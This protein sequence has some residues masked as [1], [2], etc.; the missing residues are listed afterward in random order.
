MRVVK[1]K[2]SREMRGTIGPIYPPLLGVYNAYRA[3][4]VPLHCTT[5]NNQIISRCKNAMDMWVFSMKMH[6]KC[7]GAISM[8]SSSI[9]PIAL[10]QLN[11]NINISR[12]KN[13]MDM[14]VFM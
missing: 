1:I 2:N 3:P 4:L 7:H 14:W 6:T 8:L 12:C 10:H 11:I 5:T 13:A 9:S